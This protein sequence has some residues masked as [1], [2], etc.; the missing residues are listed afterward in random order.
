MQAVK[1]EDHGCDPCNFGREDDSSLSGFIVD[2]FIFFVRCIYQTARRQKWVL[3]NAN[4]RW[5]ILE[6][7]WSAV[8]LFFKPCVIVPL[9]VR[10]S[11]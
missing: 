4:T 5:D 3:D 1:T 6:M 11:S 10:F 9:I 2:G 7:M 8:E